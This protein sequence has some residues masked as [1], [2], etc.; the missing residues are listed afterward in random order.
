MGKRHQASRRKAYG[1]RQHELRERFERAQG[2]L[3]QPVSIEVFDTEAYDDN[4]DPFTSFDLA[5]VAPGLRFAMR[6]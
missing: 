1:R 4:P 6:D 2:R 5:V 3:D